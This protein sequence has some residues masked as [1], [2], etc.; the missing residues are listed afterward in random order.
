MIFDQ[1]LKAPCLQNDGKSGKLL[2]LET[3]FTNI[4]KPDLYKHK[5]TKHKF[6]HA[7]HWLKISQDIKTV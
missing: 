3:H 7:P 1:T 2:V 6:A 4:K 5:V